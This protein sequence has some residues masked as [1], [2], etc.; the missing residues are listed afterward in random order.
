VPAADE[1]GQGA[2]PETAA[3]R[4]LLR[5]ALVALGVTA[6]LVTLAYHFVDRPVAFFVHERRLDR[7][8][9]FRWLANVAMALDAVAPVVV[10]L[11]V[12]RLAWR[13]LGRL[14]RT[15]LAASISLIV[16]VAFEYYLKFLFGRYWP[17]TW[18]DH[19]PSLIGGGAYG[20]HP[21]HFGSAYGSFPSGHTA[22]A[23]AALSVVGAAYPRWRPLCLA[24]CAGVVVGLVGMDHHFVGDAIGGACLGSLTAMYAVRFFGVGA[25]EPSRGPARASNGPAA[26]SPSAEGGRVAGP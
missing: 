12:V 25:A 9:I 6:L 17:D 5:R 10:V 1:P 18:V 24:A 16:A 4:A 11:A 23:F 14:G 19:N 2:A 20:F 3:F 15:L 21:F 13:P 7:F 8:P 22:R 26:A